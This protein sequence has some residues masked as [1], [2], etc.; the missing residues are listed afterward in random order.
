MGRQVCSLKII[1]LTESRCIG[2][3]LNEFRFLYAH[4]CNMKLIGKT[5]VNPAQSHCCKYG[6]H[7]QELNQPLADR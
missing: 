3:I 5:G 2:I 6:V 1:K 4:V 7:F